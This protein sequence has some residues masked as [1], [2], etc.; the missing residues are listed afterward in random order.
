MTD[1]INVILLLLQ[2]SLTEQSKLDSNSK[3]G[4]VLLPIPDSIL[5][6]ILLILMKACSSF[7]IELEVV[8]RKSVASWPWVISSTSLKNQNLSGSYSLKIEKKNWKKS[9]WIFLHWQ[10][11]KKKYVCC[12]VFEY[13]NF[14]AKNW[15]TVFFL[16]TDFGAKIQN[17]YEKWKWLKISHLNFRAKN[18]KKKSDFDFRSEKNKRS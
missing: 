3:S 12:A 18:P 9:F 8:L 11:K 14:R 16:M 6:R 17:Q 1:P 2:K 7:L 10:N 5:M 13:L 4:M 15:Q